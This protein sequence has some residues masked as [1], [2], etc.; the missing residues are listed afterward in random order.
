MRSAAELQKSTELFR[1]LIDNLP[2]AVN[3]KDKDGR[4]L[5]INRE[6]R[7]AFGLKQQPIIGK[8]IA[9]FRPKKQ[10]DDAALQEQEVFDTKSVVTRAREVMTRDK[11]VQEF[12]V[13]KFPILDDQGEVA[14]IG[15]IGTDITQFKE[16]QSALILAR[17]DA[18]KARMEAESANRAKSDFLA[19]MSHDLR[20]PLN[21]IIGFAEAINLQYF[22]PISKKYQ[23]YS[24][25]IRCSGEHLLSLVGDILDVTAIESGKMA[26]NK[27][28]LK[29]ADVIEECQKIIRV[30]AESLNIQIVSKIPDGLPLFFVD[31]Q[32]IKK[33]ILNLFANSL[34]FTP[35][36]GIVTIEAEAS[37]EFYFLR[38][39]DTGIGI[40]EDQ[41]A[42]ITDPFVKGTTDPYKTQDGVGLGL[43]I[44]NSLVNLHDGNL[45]IQSDIGKG[46][47]IIISFPFA[48]S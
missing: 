17:V 11:E 16:A 23:E 31:R 7:Q 40:T 18:E 13:T 46:T 20:T 32:S 19:A 30:E 24:N 33:I 48:A 22:G 42:T 28:E 6:Y 10:S 21:A 39:C 34:K 44:V 1:I 26:I 8:V 37:K 25:D 43:A 2:S 14:Q 12:L 47:T 5:I 27:E 35:S 4:Y 29:I 15:T 3:L 36:G 41:I 45:N 38:I 9:E